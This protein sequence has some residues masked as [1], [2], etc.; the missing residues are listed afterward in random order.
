MDRRS[1][2]RL[3]ERAVAMLLKERGYF[4]LDQNVR[5][6][7]FEI[8]L[9]A[10]RFDLLIVCEVR[11]RTSRRYGDPVE[12]IDSAKIRNI[13]TATSQWIEKHPT[14]RSSRLRFDAAGVLMHGETI[15]S[16]NYYED[17]F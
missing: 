9:I 6:G 13:R 7:R 12:T 17:A 11:T 1:I 14:F 10:R 8:D 3:G 5:L 16:I 2:G 4:I 15:V